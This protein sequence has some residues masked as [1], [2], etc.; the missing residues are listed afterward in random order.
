MFKTVQWKLVVIYLLLVL[1]A[2][3]LISIYLLQSLDQYYLDD[4]R[5]RMETEA[6]LVSSL[7]VR[8]MGDGHETED[9]TDLVREFGRQANNEITV[10]DENGRIMATSTG[11]EEVPGKII[12]EQ[13]TTRALAGSSGSNIRLNPNTNIREKTMAV[14]IER[15]GQILGAVYLVG[16]LQRVDDTLREVRAILFTGTAIALVITAVLGV[17]ISRTITKPVKEVTETAYAMA[18]GD[19][20]QRIDI[21]SDDEIGNLGKM[22]NHLASR[23][24][25][26]LKEMASEKSKI[27]AILTQMSDGIVAI[28]QEKEIIH[29]NPAAE[30]MLSVQRDKMLGASGQEFLERF[31]SITDIEAELDEMLD[32]ATKMP[33]A[34]N[35]TTDDNRV[36]RAQLVPFQAEGEEEKGIIIA[37]TDITEQQKLAQMR[38]ELV[39]NVSH[40]LR[41]PLTS[42]K[43]YIET[44]LDGAHKDENVAQQFLS[45]VYQETNRM[46]AMV[47]DLL[48]LSQLDRMEPVISQAPIDLKKVVQ[49]SLRAVRNLAE[50]RK[51]D[52]EYEVTG[53]IPERQEMQNDHQ[54]EVYGDQDKLTQVFTNILENAVK[55]THEGGWVFVELAYNQ[56]AAEITVSDNGIGIPDED[57]PRIFERF[58]RVEKAR[59]RSQGGTGLGLAIAREIISAH[60]GDI[61]VISKEGEGTKVKISLPLTRKGD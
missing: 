33:E 39:A 27:E 13:E 18:Q 3:E 43:S 26:T 46:T 54:L 6:E 22:F 4:Y 45:V 53:P 17:I 36:I 9:I 37:L 44:L 1:L 60:G 15:G 2:M 59:S 31:L 5:E 16:S 49:R 57:L 58:Y 42:V 28:N 52:I 50:N 32:E 38:Q 61:K 8:H 19:F 29:I 11:D 48:T 21:K 23:L 10:L 40:E 12:V 35:I 14:P 25:L 24:D 34:R 20:N 47:K 55:Y 30:K 41:T 51:V 7:L 56:E